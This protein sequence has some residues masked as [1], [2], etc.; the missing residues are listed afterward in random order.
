MDCPFPAHPATLRV[1]YKVCVSLVPFQFNTNPNLYPKSSFKLDTYN[2]RSTARRAIHLEFDISANALEIRMVQ[3][4]KWN[5]WCA[6]NCTTMPLR[7]YSKRNQKYLGYSSEMPTFYQNN[8][9]IRNTA[10]MTGGKTITIGSHDVSEKGRTDILF[11]FLG[12]HTG[13]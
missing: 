7:F 1:P 10:D 6:V 9:T 13:K 8:S 5:V 11:F 12:Q 4:P 2:I 3:S